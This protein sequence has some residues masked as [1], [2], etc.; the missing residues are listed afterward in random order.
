[1]K[2]SVVTVLAQLLFLNLGAQIRL[3][4]TQLQPKESRTNRIIQIAPMKRML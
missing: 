1:M 2:Q 4:L 3:N